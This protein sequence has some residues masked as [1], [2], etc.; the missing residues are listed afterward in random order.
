MV[1]VLST[2]P[3][4]LPLPVMVTFAFPTFTLLEYDKV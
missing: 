3:A 1:N 4:K 2:L